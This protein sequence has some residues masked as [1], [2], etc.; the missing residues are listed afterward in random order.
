MTFEEFEDAV[1]GLQAM[2][3]RKLHVLA[4]QAAPPLE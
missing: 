3:W 1:R 4:G 2:A